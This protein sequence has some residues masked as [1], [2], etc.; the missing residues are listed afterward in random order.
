MLSGAE[1]QGAD[2]EAFTKLQDEQAEWSQKFSEHILDATDSWS[3]LASADELAGVPDD[4]MAAMRAAAAADGADGYKITLK[5]PVYLPV[6]QYATNRALRETVYTAYVTRASEFGPAE[7][8]NAEA[9]QR[10]LDLRQQEA[11][12]LGYGRYA[13][14]SLVP[15]MAAS[16]EEVVTFLRDLARRARP[17]GE[18]DYAELAEFARS[19][20]GIDELQAWDMSF[21]SERLKERRYAFSEQDVKLYFTE[22]KVLEGLFRIVETLFEVKIRPDSAPVWHDSVRFFRIER[23]A[24]GRAQLVGQFFLDPYARAGKRSGAWMAD[25]RERWQRPEGGLQT[26]VAYLVCNF[27]AAGRRQAGA[28]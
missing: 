25:A 4:V 10:L 8:D 11:R 14:L 13:D 20:L 24:N 23:E 5:F 6:M 2:R 7:R 1:L 9:M 22:P 15:K 28:C 19:E 27:A 12:L 21:A 16:P 26:P 18:R 17:S 3:M